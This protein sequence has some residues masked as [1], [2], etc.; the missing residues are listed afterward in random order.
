MI[1]SLLAHYKETGLLPVWS[2]QGNETNMMI[3]NHAI[4]VIVDAYFKRI[5]NFDVQLAY[6]ACKKSSMVDSRQLDSYKKLGYIP[7]DESG[8]N[9]SVSKTLEYA[10]DDLVF[11]TICKSIT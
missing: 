4:P 8:E 5:K 11:S 6:T 3:G 2:L 10:Y 1:N 7:V 9:W